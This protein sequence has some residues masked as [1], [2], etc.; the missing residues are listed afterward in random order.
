MGVDYQNT[1]HDKKNTTGAEM[2]RIIE[3]PCHFSNRIIVKIKD[4]R[5]GST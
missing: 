3:F 4:R 1:N 2:A 5:V